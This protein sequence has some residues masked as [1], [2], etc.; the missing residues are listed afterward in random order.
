MGECLKIC[1]TSSTHATDPSNHTLIDFHKR[2]PY[3][4]FS[5][6]NHVA[7]VYQY[8]TDCTH[9]SMK[10][11]NRLCDQA[12]DYRIRLIREFRANDKL[13]AFLET[14][15]TW[16]NIPPVCSELELVV[17]LLIL[18][19]ATTTKKNNISLSTARIQ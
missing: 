7:L 3:K 1:T 19:T 5:C 8:L 14:T 16:R 18:R 13:Y 15:A 10:C 17:V 12:V 11:R 9:W 6:Q 2:R 4:R